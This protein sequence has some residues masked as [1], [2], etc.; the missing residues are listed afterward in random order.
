MVDL[1]GAGR[2]YPTPLKFQVSNSI[3]QGHLLSIMDHYGQVAHHPSMTAAALHLSLQL[4]VATKI[5]EGFGKALFKKFI[6]SR[7]PVSTVHYARPGTCFN[8]P[9]H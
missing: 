6:M 4:R 2:K 8:R 7:E 3:K 9:L 1:E 5:F